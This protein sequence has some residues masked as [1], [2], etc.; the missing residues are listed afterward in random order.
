MSCMLRAPVPPDLLPSRWPSLDEAVAGFRLSSV[1]VRDF[2]R[3][4]AARTR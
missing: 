2:P 1:T 3:A 4:R